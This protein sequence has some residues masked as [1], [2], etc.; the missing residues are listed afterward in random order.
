MT[1]SGV[2]DKQY[3]QQLSNQVV[4]PALVP[5]AQQPPCVIMLG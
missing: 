3:Q 2:S 5:M 1:T 4:L